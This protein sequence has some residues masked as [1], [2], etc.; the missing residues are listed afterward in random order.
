MIPLLRLYSCKYSA[1]QIELLLVEHVGQFRQSKQRLLLPAR[2]RLQL[3]LLSY[4]G[5]VRSTLSSLRG[6]Q[7]TSNQ[8][9]KRKICDSLKFTRRK[10]HDSAA[11]AAARSLMYM[12]YRAC[13]DD[14]LTVSTSYSLLIFVNYKKINS[15][16]GF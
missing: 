5:H 4:S 10:L 1:K 9:E 8:Q 13:L 6:C 14:C 16:D 11:I 2:S 12:P 15:L 3:V 7:Q